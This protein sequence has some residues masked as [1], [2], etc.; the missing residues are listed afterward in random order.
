MKQKTFIFLTHS[1]YEKNNYISLTYYSY[2]VPYIDR[3]FK[4]INNKSLKFNKSL[5]LMV[6]N[7]KILK[8]CLKKPR[9]T[10]V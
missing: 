5:Y 3:R 6:W 2:I 9:L 10:S 8:A 7:P 1:I 4:K